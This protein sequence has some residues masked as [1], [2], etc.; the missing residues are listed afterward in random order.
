MSRDAHLS[1][2]HL[3]HPHHADFFEDFCRPPSSLLTFP[4][5]STNHSNNPTN[6]SHPHQQQQQSSPSHP[7][8]TTTDPLA[9]HPL[10]GHFL[11]FEPIPL[12]PHLQP[13]NPEDE[14]GVV[15]DMHAAFGIMAALPRDAVNSGGWVGRGA[16]MNNGLAGGPGMGTGN[17]ADGVVR[18]GVWRDLGM[19]G[20]LEGPGGEEGNNGGSGGGGRGGIGG[21]VNGGVGAGGVVQGTGRRREGVRR[22]FESRM[23]R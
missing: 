22:G 19:E 21:R 14:D 15:P 7:T 11:P 8:T 4:S 3:H 5:S 23:M 16:M 13:L 18:E 12:P 17:G 2:H 6:A 10:P 9:P 20:V 1:P